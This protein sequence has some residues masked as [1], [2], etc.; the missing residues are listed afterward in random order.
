M[1]VGFGPR[2]SSSD[3]CGRDAAGVER[4]RRWRP[5]AGVMLVAALGLAGCATPPDDP[6]ARAEF[7][8]IND[9]LEPMNRYVFE[10]NRALD[11]L[12]LRPIADTYRTVVPEYA[13]TRVN[14]VLSNMNEPLTAANALLQGRFEDAGT[15]LGRFAINSVLG[16]AGLFD[17]ATEMG[18]ARERADFGQTLY[19]WG[20]DSGPYLVLPVFGPSNTRDAVGLGADTAMDPTGW[21]F[22]TQGLTEVNFGR[23]GGSG[24]SQRAA[25]I[26]PLD[27]LEE[28]SIDFYAQLRSVWRQRRAAQLAGEDVP[29]FD[30][31][32]YG[33][34]DSFN[35]DET[36]EPSAPA[37]GE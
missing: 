20:V 27:A 25:A 29:N 28:S 4:R 5:L 30:Y 21:I 15:S 26:D 7:E 1:Q 32:I 8:R 37:S 22:S 24:V 16:V 36:L 23:A 18:I 12:V 10:L 17:V 9:P 2:L 13:Q 34:Y 6:V 19:T 35:G 31:D 11:I 3:R 14:R 33:D